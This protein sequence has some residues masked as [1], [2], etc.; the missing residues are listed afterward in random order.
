MLPGK[1]RTLKVFVSDESASGIS[2]Y[3]GEEVTSVNQ[4]PTYAIEIHSFS[5]SKEAEAFISGIA[6]VGIPENMVYD[7]QV[8]DYFSSQSVIIAWLKKSRPR[9]TTV[10]EVIKVVE[11][12]PNNYDQE[13]LKAHWQEHAHRSK[14]ARAAELAK[15]RPVLL[16]AKELDASLKN[17]TAFSEA[18]SFVLP[19]GN[20]LIVYMEEGHA[21]YTV[22]GSCTALQANFNEEY[23]DLLIEIASKHRLSYNAYSL[24]AQP[25]NDISQLKATVQLVDTAVTECAET[26]KGLMPEL[27][28]E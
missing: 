2:L 4:L 26:L 22:T 17:S 11:H 23:R 19:S 28:I 12:A 13:S 3:Q 16:V 25:L 27:E 18:V 7:W 9:G 24:D 10:E 5:S 20:V 1:Q 6:F 8:D 15:V 14:A 21:P